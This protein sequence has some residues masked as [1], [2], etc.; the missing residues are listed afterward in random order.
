LQEY[1]F[2]LRLGRFA[3]VPFKR[4]RSPVVFGGASR[5]ATGHISAARR[6]AVARGPVRNG[7]AAYLVNLR[8][9]RYPLRGV[10]Y[11]YRR[12]ASLSLL[13]DEAMRHLFDESSIASGAFDGRKRL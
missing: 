3:P 8:P 1:H 5:R 10:N 9:F 11:S 13:L 7:V 12:I 4:E 2:V 6:R